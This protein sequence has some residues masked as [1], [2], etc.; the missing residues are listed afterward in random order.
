ME[1]LKVIISG[2]GTGGHIFPAVA[3]AKA[4]EKK[5]SDIEILFIGAKDRMEMTKI[6]SE[7]Y[8]IEGLWI[9]GLQRRLTISNLSFPF[10]LISSLCRAKK[11]IKKFEPDIAIGTGG[12]ASGPLLYVAA[13]N[14]IP[15]LVQEQN[16]Y[17][18]ITN[19]I[20]SKV[21]DKV[22]VAYDKMERFFPKEKI[23]FSGNPIRED[24]LEFASKKDMAITHFELDDNKKTVLVIGGSLGARTINQVIDKNIDFF[25]QNNLN[26]IWQTG[27]SYNEKGVARIKE[28]SQKGIHAYTFIKEMDLAFAAADI[29]ISR[30]GAIAVSELC[31]IGKPCI[32]IPSPNVSE[33]HQTKNAQAV[34]NKSAALLVKDKDADSKLVNCLRGLCE[35]EDLQEKLAR[36]IKLLAVLDAA[37]MIADE[38]LKLSKK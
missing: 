28:K 19:K 33:D 38:A 15:T 32:L 37:E 13:N 35:D 7:G 36:N 16:S 3:I 17:P 14:N 6:P 10:K 26:L 12:Y 31:H 29:I 11:I 30:A 9:S 25:S 2:G 4:L 21:V 23:I 8:K 22:C 1:R 18:G 27:T 5:V 20:L 34:V 24:V